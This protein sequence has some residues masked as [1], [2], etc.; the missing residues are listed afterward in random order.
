MQ[1]KRRLY[2]RCMIQSSARVLIRRP[3]E[4]SYLQPSG[5][6]GRERATAM[7]FDTCTLAISWA[8]QQGLRGV[9]V[10]L[11]FEDPPE[12]FVPARL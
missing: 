8:M 6:F 1:V 10:L 11:A 7:E 3:D 9:E 2:V 12:D 5:D 4:Q